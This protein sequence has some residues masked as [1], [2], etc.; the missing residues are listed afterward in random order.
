[1][2][3]EDAM[4]G[5]DVFCGVSAKD[6]LS[7]A[8]VK[9][10]ADNPVIFAMANPNPEITYDDA[11]AARNDVI[12]ATGR[13]D[14]PNQVNNVLGFPFIFRGALDVRA[15]TI[16]EEMKIAASY[17]LANLAKEDVPDGVIR[18]Y[19][20]KRIEFGREYIIPKPFDPRVLFWE[21][22]AVAKAAMDSGVAKNPIKDFDHYRDYLEGRLGKSREVMRFFIHKAQHLQKRIVFP[23]GEELKILRAAQ[24]LIDDKIAKPILIGN[25]D[26]IKRNVEELGLDFDY[27]KIEIFDPE[28]NMKY[29]KYLEEFYNLRKRKG[30]SY[31]DAKRLLRTPA[32]FGMMMVR[33]GD[34]DGL[35]S[36]L[37]RNYPDTI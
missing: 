14:Y 17:A 36:G 19:G 26:R 12:I 7:K 29:D 3:I 11:K 28:N 13:S 5:A 4:K 10:M 37:T 6:I 33:S 1:R 31:T 18:A 16:N 20:G 21:A 8:M 15:T 9:S 22:P 25:P 35:I 2:S 24:I 32:I 34:A 30:I 27:S 23:E